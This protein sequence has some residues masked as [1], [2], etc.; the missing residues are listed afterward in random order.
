MLFLGFECKTISLILNGTLAYFEQPTQP[1]T[2]F[3]LCSLLQLE[4]LKALNLLQFDHVIH[5]LTY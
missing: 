3:A 4:E 2:G 1:N 5:K